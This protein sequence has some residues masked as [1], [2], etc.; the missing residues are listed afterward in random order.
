MPQIVQENIST[1]INKRHSKLGQLFRFYFKI[2][3]SINRAT[4][5]D[6]PLEPRFVAHG[7]AIRIWRIS[8]YDKHGN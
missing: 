6:D 4:I 8:I 2:S 7:T 3:I 1:I 5:L